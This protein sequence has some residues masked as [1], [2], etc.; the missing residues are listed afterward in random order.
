MGL[1][2]VFKG[3][4]LQS[5]V[6]PEVTVEKIE[7]VIEVCDAKECTGSCT[8]DD[9]QANDALL[10]DEGTFAK[11]KIDQ[12]EP[13]Y[14]SSKTSKIHFVIPTSQTD[15]AHDACA[16]KTGSVQGLVQSWIDGNG[17]KYAN[18]ESEG[19]TIRCSVSS[20]PIDMLD[21]EVM[22]NTK[23]DVLIFPHFLRLRS[24]KSKDVAD[25]LNEV[26]PL[27]LKNNREALLTKDYVD[28][29]ND[30][31][32]IFLCSHRTRDKRCGITAPILEKHF[33]KHLK[34]C[35]LYRDNSDFRTDGS[36]V[37]YINHV[38]GH[39]FAA[40]VIIYL[41]K[42][43]QLIWLGRV[44]PVHTKPIVDCL[45]VPTIP[46]LPYPEKVRCVAKYSF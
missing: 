21:I 38:G 9:A 39:K 34:S 35:R 15:W 45:I 40:N 28:E 2:N 26:V 10:K 25:V 46:K 5:R 19:E 20:L 4:S 42:S 32:Y 24:I 36:R 7:E 41:K 33:N 11:L 18:I 30:N 23:N 37:A 8:E 3:F 44:T 6:K 43:H 16:E 27:L 13:L 12:E 29:I 17:S 14:G 31:S 1:S 22:K